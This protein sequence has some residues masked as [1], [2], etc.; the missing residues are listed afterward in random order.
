VLAV[1]PLTRL[2]AESEPTAPS[3]KVSSTSSWPLPFVSTQ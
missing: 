1:K 2:F 3:T